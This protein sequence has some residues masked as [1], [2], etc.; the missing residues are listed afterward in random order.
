M[1]FTFKKAGKEK[2]EE[3]KLYFTQE[4][5]D[6]NDVPPG[7]TPAP[8]DQMF[9]ADKSKIQIEF[10]GYVLEN[11]RKYQIMNEHTTNIFELV[12]K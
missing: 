9:S 11:N 6:Y 8:N 3:M 7:K 10:E 12:K 4:P 2:K 5:I 1:F